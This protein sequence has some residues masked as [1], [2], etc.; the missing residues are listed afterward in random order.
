[1]LGAD[2]LAR[3]IRSYGNPMQDFVSEFLGKSFDA[4]VH[5]QARYQ[6]QMRRAMDTT[7]L[8]TFRKLTEENLKSW[9]SMQDAFLNPKNKPKSEE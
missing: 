9:Q 4:F 6:E 2:F 3:I 5:Q 7:P 8:E 1:M